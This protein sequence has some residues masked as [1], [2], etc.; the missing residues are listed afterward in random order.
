MV[1][2]FWPVTAIFIFVYSSALKQLSARLGQ[3]NY[4]LLALSSSFS[5]PMT[6]GSM[7]GCRSSEAKFQCKGP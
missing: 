6:Q 7:S 4:D 2:K 5:V 1:R 3:G